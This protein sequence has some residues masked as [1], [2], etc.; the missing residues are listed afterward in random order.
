MAN[1]TR[2]KAGESPE[3][4]LQRSFPYDSRILCSDTLESFTLTRE[5]ARRLGLNDVMSDRTFV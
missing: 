5:E 3:E 2:H 1:D 4:M